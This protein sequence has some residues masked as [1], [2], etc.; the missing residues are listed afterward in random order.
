MPPGVMR[1][2]DFS[3]NFW[4]KKRKSLL[5]N[6]VQREKTRMSEKEEGKV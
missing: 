5:R 1:S 6:E 4:K 3:S 2:A